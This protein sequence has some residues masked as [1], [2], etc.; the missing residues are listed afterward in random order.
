MTYTAKEQSEIEGSPVELYEF[1]LAGQ[2][3]RSTSQSE[4]VTFDGFVY[5][6][7]PIKRNNPKL[8]KERSG[9]QL[10]V[11]VP[12][13]ADVAQEYID[14]VPTA[15]MSLTIFRQHRTDTP[16]PQTITFWKGFIT[17]VSYKDE[18]AEMTCEP[19]QSLFAREIPRQV[20]S[21]LCNHV[22][23]DTGCRVSR[24]SFSDVV[25]VTAISTSGDVLTLDSLSTARPADT[26]FYDGGFVER[27]NGDKRLILEYT[28]ATDEV[29]I[30][31]PFDGLAVGEDVTARA[32][33]AHDITTCRDK[34]NIV[35]NFGGF[36]WSPNTNPFEVG[37]DN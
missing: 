11:T 34:F 21:G 17:N 24:V 16:T 7:A 14:I 29:R 36:P 32:G 5:L 25:E 33:C 1:K 10:L 37:V 27:A 13:S 12:T 30:L 19:I 35:P 6:P 23:F 28:F 18:I 2:V 26:T 9:V 15:K 31:L 3:F 22:L 20:Y 8:S 4:P